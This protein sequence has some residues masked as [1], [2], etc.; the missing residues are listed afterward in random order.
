MEYLNNNKK[1]IAIVMI[2]IGLV[3]IPLGIYFISNNKKDNSN[4]NED[5]VESDNNK[6]PGEEKVDDKDNE[7]DKDS[8]EVKK[9]YEIAKMDTKIESF[10]QST[11]LN[12]G[13]GKYI[14][15]NKETNI[16]DLDR[17]VFFLYRIIRFI[18]NNRFNF[19]YVEYEKDDH[20]TT[21]IE[22][23]RSELKKV[24][25]TLFGD[26]YT[27]DDFDLY[28]NRLV[29]SI[30]SYNKEKD[31][32]TF[33]KHGIFADF[34]TIETK[35]IKVEKDENYIYLYEKVGIITTSKT[36]YFSNILDLNLDYNK[37]KEFLE[38]NKDK[39]KDLNGKDIWDYED[40]LSTF[41]YVLKK[42]KNGE[43]H[44]DSM[45]YVELK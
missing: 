32:Y 10:T 12:E 7:I 11:S 8:E 43:Y 34:S 40:D 19:E 44:L 42:D 4:S 28:R 27:I 14:Y 38:N 13:L 45:G 6:T 20:Y 15:S 25:H 22:I 23:K 39:A 5:V 18:Q 35:L 31:T 37:E 2:V 36:K 29:G 33:I 30:Q 16:K 21:Q 26:K 41:R 24:L 17:K 3:L 1:K 9:L